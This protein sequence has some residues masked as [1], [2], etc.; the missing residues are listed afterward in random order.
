MAMPAANT[1]EQWNWRTRCCLTLVSKPRQRSSVRLAPELSLPFENT[2]RAA[3]LASPSSGEA[4]QED[5]A[6][7]RAVDEADLMSVADDFC[8][9][10]QEPE[11]AALL[12]PMRADCPR[13]CDP[14]WHL[15]VAQIEA[16]RSLD[17][18]PPSRS[19]SA[20]ARSLLTALA[21]IALNER[22]SPLRIVLDQGTRA[23]LDRWWRA[24]RATRR[25]RRA[26]TQDHQ[27]PLFPLAA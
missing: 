25:P 22:V 16:R 12:R 4:A 19:H 10:A 21:L 5:G 7:L 2:A 9:W 3:A 17:V 13:P 11:H 8:E 24:G 26:A 23:L 20:F 15:A 27:L 6:S 1:Q 14:V 18:D